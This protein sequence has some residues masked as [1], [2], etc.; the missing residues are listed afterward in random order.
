MRAVTSGSVDRVLLRG[1]LRLFARLPAPARRTIVHWAAPRFTVGVLLVLRSGGRILVLGQRQHRSGTLP[2]GL[3][4]RGE[5]PVTA[6]RRETREEL[7]LEVSV[8]APAATVVDP[9][10]R[11]VD[12]VFVADLGCAED[13]VCSGEEVVT[14]TWQPPDELADAAPA[15]RRAITAAAE[16]GDQPAGRAWRSVR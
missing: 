8:S 14:A 16:R 2:G 12:L 7:G 3:L 6:L 9:L 10:A 1:G 11:R 4:D 15:T 5:D 13:V